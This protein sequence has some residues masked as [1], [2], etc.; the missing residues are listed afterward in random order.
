MDGDEGGVRSVLRAIDLLGLF[1]EDRRTWSIRELTEASGLAKTT[2]I[3]LVTTCEQRGLLWTHADGQV[4]IGPGLL[5][6]AKL[7]H[8][9]WQLSEPVRQVMRELASKCGETVNIYVRSSAARVCVAQHEGPQHIRHVV[10]VGDELPLWAGAAGKVL[11]IGAPS[12]VVDQ[13]AALSPYGREFAGELRRRAGTAAVDGHAVS[14]GERELGASGI[15]A[16]VTDREGRIIAA[17]AVGGP[18]TRFT[19]ERVAEFVTAVVTS[20]QWISRLG[21]DP[22]R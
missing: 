4:T 21:L 11:L 8:A 13:V 10:R 18:T 6:W 3:R 7:G 16:P 15:A 5:R 1:T 14:H 17:L 12:T 22:A 20:A 19:D 2:V 9:A